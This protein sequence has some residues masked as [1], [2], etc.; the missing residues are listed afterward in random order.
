[1]VLQF[2]SSYLYILERV[3]IDVINA[4]LLDS[5]VFNILYTHTPV[6]LY[7]SSLAATSI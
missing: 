7:A 6:V 5:T 2:S 3:R 1:M 4:E